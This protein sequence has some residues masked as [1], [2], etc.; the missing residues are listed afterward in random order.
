MSR[1]INKL[2]IDKYGKFHSTKYGL[3]VL[4]QW[5][6]EKWKFE[7]DCQVMFFSLVTGKALKLHKDLTIDGLGE[8]KDKWGKSLF[9]A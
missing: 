6:W 3:Y 9:Y 4:F 1:L 5:E 2:P 7:K 8:E